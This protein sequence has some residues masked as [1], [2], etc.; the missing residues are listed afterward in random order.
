MLSGG[1]FLGGIDSVSKAIFG[2]RDRAGNV[3][4]VAVSHEFGPCGMEHMSPGDHA[5]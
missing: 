3:M 1:L 2:K 5:S 4:N